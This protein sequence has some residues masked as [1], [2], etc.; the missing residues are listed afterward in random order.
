MVPVDE[1]TFYLCLPVEWTCP[2][3]EFQPGL[4]FR[5]TVEAVGAES[6]TK[7]EAM[8]ANAQ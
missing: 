4:V 8:L 6:P 7:A 3:A 2:L 1:S 5:L